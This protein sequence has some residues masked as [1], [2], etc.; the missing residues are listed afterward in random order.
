MNIANLL[1][2]SRFI[3]IPIIIY[4]L[5]LDTTLYRLLA[6]GLFVLSSVSDVLDGYLARRLGIVTQFGRIIDPL[7]D[8]VTLIAIY[9]FLTLS[10]NI[11]IWGGTVILLRELIVFGLSATF[12]LKGM[13]IIHPSSLGKAT[14]AILYITAAV[15]IFNLQPLGALLVGLGAGMAVL[16]A[17]D[18]MRTTLSVL[19]KTS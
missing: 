15:N 17:A 19:F 9:F 3:L 2:I 8:K 6:G 5:V 18:Y 1:T 10:N 14:A 12:Y 16:S 11:N 7:A 13:D 4:L